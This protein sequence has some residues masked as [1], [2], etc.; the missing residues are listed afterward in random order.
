M[1]VGFARSAVNDLGSVEAFAVG[2][3]ASIEWIL[4]HRDDIAVSDLGPLERRHP[5][6][7]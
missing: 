3:G 6:A 7:V 1:A 4:E 5:L 2:V